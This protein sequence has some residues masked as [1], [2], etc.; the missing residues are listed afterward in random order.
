MPGWLLANRLTATVAGVSLH[1]ATR[2]RLSKE[3]YVRFMDT[4][5]E[6]HNLPIWIDDNSGP[7]SDQM[8]EQLAILNETLAIK[9]MIF[10]F[11]ELSGDRGQTENLRLGTVAHNLKGIAKTLEIPVIAISQLNRDVDTRKNKI[12]MLADLRYSGMIE[13]LAD[14][15]VFIRR[16]QYYVERGM[17]ID[18]DGT[19]KHGIANLYVS[20]NRNGPVGSVRLGFNSDWI[21]FHEIERVPITYEEGY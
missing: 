19:D 20:K 2:G 14:V 4:E 13:Q 11:M 9:L 5:R 12:P 6:L 18:C 21:K 15:V 3:D 1:E 10:D 17:N 7:S 16:P 8:L